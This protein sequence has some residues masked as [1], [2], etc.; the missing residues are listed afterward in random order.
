MYAKM[1]VFPGS[2]A[3]FIAPATARAFR[4]SKLHTRRQLPR[5]GWQPVGLTGQLPAHQ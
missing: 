1:T 3:R 4:N 2:N 5:K